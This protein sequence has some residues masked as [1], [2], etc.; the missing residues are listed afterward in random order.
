MILCTLI[1]DTSFCKCTL[2]RNIWREREEGNGRNVD[3][4]TIPD[5]LK[6]NLGAG[7]VDD[8]GLKRSLGGSGLRN[9]HGNYEGNNR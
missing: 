5:S 7:S 6:N 2:H 1:I 4:S 3:T 8:A 9:S